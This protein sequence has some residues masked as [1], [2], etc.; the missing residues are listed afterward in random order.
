MGRAGGLSTRPDRA[1][2]DRARSRGATA[3]VLVSLT[4]LLL[5]L[6]GAPARGV[7]SV[8]PAAPPAG[9]PSGGEI[10]IEVDASR[11]VGSLN[12]Q[13]VGFGWHDGGAP[14]TTVEPLRP[15]LIRVDAALE[16]VSA[17]P[18]EPLALEPLLARV[19]AIRA[20][21]A[22]PLVILSYMPAWLG[23]PVAWGR[24]PTRVRPYDLD[25]WQSV[26]HDVVRALATA[27]APTL[28]FEAWNEPDVPLFWQDL[29]SSWVDTVERSARAVAQVE[30]ETGL[31]LAFGGAATAVPDPVY[32]E[33]FLER[34]RDPTLP[35][36]FVSWH[37]YGNYPFFGPDGAEFD[38]TEPVQ[39]VLGRQ[40]PSA[41]PAA[42]GYQVGFMRNLVDAL[43]AGS[44]RAAPDLVL[45]EW[46]LSAAGFDLRHDT[47]SNAAFAASVLSEMQG[48]G[49]DAAAFFRANDTRGVPGEHGAVRV[50]GE[51]KPVWYAFDLW[52]RQADAVVSATFADARDGDLWAVATADATHIAVLLSTFRADPQATEPI[53]VS[54]RVSGRTV[55][56]VGAVVRRIDGAH[57]GGGPPEPVTQSAGAVVVTLPVP[58]VALVEIPII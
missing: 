11:I 15:R 56:V 54:I 58:G 3:A 4:T 55:A 46:N 22:E 12:R 44:G 17:G 48:A 25:A 8:V 28:R 34:F 19:A 41:T 47:A 1:S 27:D 5:G 49:L 2:L 26:V 32:L 6:G 42:F 30:Q 36:D 57:P 40:N 16:Q 53:T 52:Q 14:L 39:P 35:L 38:V 29:P 23:E 31:D 10:P 43:L 50:D 13:L 21:G 20:I 24:D 33:Q 9:A 37:Y 45:D 51:R 18:E 7:G